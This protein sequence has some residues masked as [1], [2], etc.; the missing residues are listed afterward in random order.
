MPYIRRNNHMLLQQDNARPHVAR[1]TFDFLR[2]SNIRTLDNWL[3]L[4]ADFNP[5]EKADKEVE[6]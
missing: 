2:P 5:I 3:A 1:L 4:S 6:T